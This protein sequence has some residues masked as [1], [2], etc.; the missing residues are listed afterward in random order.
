MD[1]IDLTGVVFDYLTVI[2]YVGLTGHYKCRK[3]GT[4][5]AYHTWECLCKCGKT[6]N[7]RST[8]LRNKST[9]SCGCKKLTY[10]PKWT[11]PP[12]EAAKGFIYGT[13]KSSAKDRGHD[14]LLSL[15]EFVEIA[16]GNCY[17]CG[18][19]PHKSA[20]IRKDGKKRSTVFNGDW[21]YNGIDRK[22][23][24]IGYIKDNCVPCCW[25]C[26]ELKSN[27]NEDEFIDMLRKII[28]NV[29]NKENK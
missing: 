4:T 28:N 12:G 15:E 2:K 23:N 9:V 5:K 10:K 29:D 1:V 8:K 18:C 6:L 22:D 26:N 24:S 20:Q 11:K 3:Y 13:Y 17:Y 27:Y 14:F 25:P 7:V 19:L 21:K 16:G